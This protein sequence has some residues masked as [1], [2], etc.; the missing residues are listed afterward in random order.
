MYLQ[1]LGLPSLRGQAGNPCVLAS[2]QVLTLEE[3]GSE[4]QLG[5]VRELEHV[6][7]PCPRLQA[8]ETTLPL[9]CP[10]AIS[11]KPGLEVGASRPNLEPFLLLQVR[12]G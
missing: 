9:S 10:A 8:P 1:S 2:E 7:E 5:S 11:N 6:Q 4:L 12:A 3:H